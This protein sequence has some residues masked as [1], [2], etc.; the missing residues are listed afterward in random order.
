MESGSC[1]S[2]GFGPAQHG[3]LLLRPQPG[4]LGKTALDGAAIEPDIVELAIVETA[5]Q[6]EA[7]LACAL[8]NERR[9]KAIDEAAGAREEISDGPSDRAGGGS[10][11]SAMI[12]QSHGGHP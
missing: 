2:S 6:Y 3:G 11:A 4:G 5:E 12:Q 10:I 8:F 9:D 1:R 7:G